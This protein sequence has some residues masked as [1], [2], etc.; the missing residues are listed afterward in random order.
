MNEILTHAI[1]IL[2]NGGIA[3]FPTDTACG[4]GCRIDDTYAV[5]RLFSIKG[6]S[7]TK[8]T[9]VLVN[10]IEMA[11]EYASDIPR[12]VEERLLKPFWPGALTVVLHC[13]TKKV[14]ALVRGQSDTLGMRMPNFAQVLQIINALG[15][16]IIGTSANIASGPT[17]YRTDDVVEEL[18]SQV[19]IVIPGSCPIGGSS[20]VIDTTKIPW[21]IMRQGALDL[22][23]V[24][25]RGKDK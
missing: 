4:I 22:S 25:D 7:I 16:P 11:R 3:I 9:P 19:D 1:E 5:N 17:P 18:K 10:S 15:V 6:R 13:K 12:E 20:T 21:K 24:Y 2:R 23:G 14:P 8:A